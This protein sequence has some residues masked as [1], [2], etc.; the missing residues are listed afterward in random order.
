MLARKVK[1][2]GLDVVVFYIVTPCP[3]SALYDIALENNNIPEEINFKNMKFGIPNM[4][5]TVI[6]P[7]VIQYTRQLVYALL[8]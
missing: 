5:N 1:D 7:E 4:I 6:P 2:A 8:N 3:G